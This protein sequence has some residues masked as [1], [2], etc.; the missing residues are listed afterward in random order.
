[1]ISQ[2][3]PILC[4]KSPRRRIPLEIYKHK[5]IQHHVYQQ[6]ENHINYTDL[7]CPSLISI[8]PLYNPTGNKSVSREEGGKNESQEKQLEMDPLVVQIS[9][10]ESGFT[11]CLACRRCS[12]NSSSF[13]IFLA[14]YACTAVLQPFIIN[15]ILL[16]LFLLSW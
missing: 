16:F 13:I 9:K 1:M 8:F 5:S 11:Q 12:V 4:Q 3:I 2:K 14:F 6:D 7:V 15:A 10:D